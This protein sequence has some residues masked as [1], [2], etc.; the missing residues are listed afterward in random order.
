MDGL[1]GS[2]NVMEQTFIY[3]IGCLN[4]TLAVFGF[5]YTLF[6]QT[7]PWESLRVGDCPYSVNKQA[8]NKFDIKPTVDRNPQLLLAACR[9]N[10]S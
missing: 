7:S 8:N 9:K 10:T 3:P 6:L 2:E 4:L 1:G 5:T